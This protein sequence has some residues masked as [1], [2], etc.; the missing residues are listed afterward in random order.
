MPVDFEKCQKKKGS[1]IRTVSGPSKKHN[2][3]KNEY[4]KYCID[5]SGSSFRGE[6]E[7]NKKAEV[8]EEG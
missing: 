6:V 3:G 4:V 8:M 1:K 2:L 5:S 7:K